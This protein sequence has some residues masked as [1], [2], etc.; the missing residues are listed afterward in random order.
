LQS[1]RPWTIHSTK[2][3]GASVGFIITDARGERF[4]LKFDRAG[5]PEVET[6]AEVILNKLLWAC[7]YNVAEDHVVYF[8]PEDLVIAPDAI[9]KD[10]TGVLGRLDRAGLARSLRFTGETHVH[11]AR[12]PAT[13]T[14]RVIGV[15]RP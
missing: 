7:G 3:G 11:V 5:F 1:R 13:D 6:A 9:V 2:V 4:L 10:W 8:R 12:D 14:P 15:W